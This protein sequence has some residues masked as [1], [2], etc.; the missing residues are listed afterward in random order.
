VDNSLNDSNTKEEYFD[1][2]DKDFC[3]SF[4][5]IPRLST[6]S[7]SVGN[8]IGS[9]AFGSVHKGKWR[10][11]WVALKK[12]DISHAKNYL[13]GA[14]SKDESCEEQILEALQWEVS[15]LST[16][17]HPN[18][19]QFYGL[20]QHKSKIHLVMEFC[21]G[22]TLQKRL[23]L[24]SNIPL[25]M[26]WQWSFEMNHGLSYLHE[27]GILHRDLKCENILLDKNNTAK[28]CRQSVGQRGHRRNTRIVESES[29]R[30][31]R[32]QETGTEDL[33]GEETR[34]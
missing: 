11:G 33:G 10:N 32:G 19:V 22:G 4:I 27:N 12:I 14:L 9:G 15:R 25:F 2:S 31:G 17:S 3:Q 29:D 24:S 13:Y 30:V 20:F 34:R 23:E 18:C 16:V 21:E 26:I 7:I 1:S 6:N 5:G 28:Q 8:Y